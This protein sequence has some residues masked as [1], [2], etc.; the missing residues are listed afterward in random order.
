ML[1]NPFDLGGFKLSYGPSDNQG[2]D[3]VFL[4]QIQAG[5]SFKP[6]TSLGQAGG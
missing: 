4:T 3:E 1:N 5:G 6:I 2:S